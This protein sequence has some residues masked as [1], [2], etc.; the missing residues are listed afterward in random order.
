MEPFI[1]F[2][3]RNGNIYWVKVENIRGIQC[4]ITD[5]KDSYINL[6]LFDTD[7]DAYWE[8]DVVETMEEIRQKLYNIGVFVY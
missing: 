2:H 4:V 7:H 6:E 5:E 3:L 8:I 1:E